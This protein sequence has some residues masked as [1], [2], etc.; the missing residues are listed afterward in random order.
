MPAR[1]SLVD[2]AYAAVRSA[3]LSGELPAGAVT[4]QAAL[5]ARFG[6]GRT[7]LREALRLLQREGLIESDHFQRLRIAPFSV[8]DA[9]ELYAQRI[10]SEA[11][12]VR[13][14]V[15]RM[16]AGERARL[17]EDL[18]ELDQLSEARR[19]SEW[20]VA[21]RRFHHRLVSHGGHRLTAAIADL[22]DHAERYRRFH[23]EAGSGAAWEQSR[24]DHRAI[25]DAYDV[26]D[27]RAA[28]AEL[29]RHLA[30]TALAIVAIAAPDY[31]PV[32]LRTALE[33]AA[34]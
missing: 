6:L 23:L 34:G 12:A 26:G 4:S 11:L 33:L 28:A 9:E 13:V 27:A 5:G 32:R 10:V 31:D 8:A 22:A 14:T 17:R 15:P 1:P 2:G 19:Y 21:H 29:A 24:R 7:P 20:D 30:R 25:V 16:G 3:V 18:A